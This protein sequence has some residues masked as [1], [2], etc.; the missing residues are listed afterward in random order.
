MK[1]N[2]ANKVFTEYR[3]NVTAI[4]PIKGRKYTMTHSDQ[5]G[6]LF[7]TIGLEYAE[8]KVLPIRD[9]VRLEWSQLGNK[10]V[11]YG[12]VMIDGEG[13]PG[14]PHNRNAI[15]QKEMPTALKAIRYG[16]HALFEKYPE[17]D[18]TP[19]FIQ[20]ISHNTMFNKL[21]H[22]GNIGNYRP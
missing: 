14:S 8:D 11:L 2:N 4:H 3:N 20:F 19:V 5:T 13:I 21:Y 10:P 9:E 18:K 12:E 1:R 7:V 17:L 22:V 6:D 15:F 16:D